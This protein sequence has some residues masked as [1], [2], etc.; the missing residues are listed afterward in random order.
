MGECTL[1]ALDVL[2]LIYIEYKVYNRT[3]KTERENM[4]GEH[5]ARLD[6]VGVGGD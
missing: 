5:G 2:L 1:R 6:Y 3:V 4:A